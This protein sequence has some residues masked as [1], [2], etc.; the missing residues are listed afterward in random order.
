ML[1]FM[2]VCVCFCT[3]VQTFPLFHCLS[4]ALSAPNTTSVLS[5]VSLPDSPY[6]QEWPFPPTSLFLPVFLLKWSRC[7]FSRAAHG[8]G[9]TLWP[10]SPRSI[11]SFSLSILITLLFIDEPFSSTKKCF[12]QYETFLLCH[13]WH[14]RAAYAEGSEITAKILL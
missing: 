2:H 14:F 6:H 4:V 5:T 7:C 1:A 9:C 13:W 12:F 10:C 11:A 8:G 3:L